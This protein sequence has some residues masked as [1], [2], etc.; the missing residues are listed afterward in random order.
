[1]DFVSN[2]KGREGLVPKSVLTRKRSLLA[3]I[4]V[5]AL[6]ASLLAVAAVPASAHSVAITTT[7][8]CPSTIPSAGFTDIGS[9]DATTQLAINCLVAFGISTGTT[10]TT[11]SPNDPVLRWQ[12]ALFL[13]RQA[14]DHGLTIPT[15]T[16]QGFTDIGG[17]PQATQDAINQVAAMEISRGTTT[18]TF[19]PNDVVSRWQ[20]ALFLYRLAGLAGV[21]VADDPTHNEFGD[22]AGFSAETRTAIN[23]L[24]DGHIALGTGGSNF[25]PNDAVFRW[26]MALFLTRTLA[27]DNIPPPAGLQVIVTP[28]DAV[29]LASGN[30][31]AF[32]AT[33]KN[34]DGTPYTGVVTLW[35]LDVDAS[36]NAITS[37]IDPAENVDWQAGT[38][39]D[40][41]VF[42][43]TG[44]PV[45]GVFAGT[46]GVVSGVIRHDGLAAEEVRVYAIRDANANAAADSGEPTDVGGLT[47]FSGV[48]VAEAADGFS[49]VVTVVSVNAAGDSFIA[50][51]GA[52][53]CGNGA[54][55]DCT[56]NHDSG[57]LFLIGGAADTQAN[58]EA[59]LNTGDDVTVTNYGAATADQSTFDITNDVDPPLTITDPVAAGVNVDANTYAVKGTAVPGYTVAVYYDLNNN[60]LKDA[61]EAKLGETTAAADGTWTVVVPLIQNTVNTLVATQRPTPATSDTGTGT[62]V[63]D[64]TETA[65]AAATLENPVGNTNGGLSTILDGGDTLTLDFNEPMNSDFAGDSLQVTDGTDTVTLTNGGN[66]SFAVGGDSSIIVV[67]VTGILPVTVNGNA[68]VQNLNGFFGTDGLAVNINTDPDRAFTLA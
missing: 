48:P 21:T 46:D 29:T 68:S 23:F 26:S 37:P 43:A 38:I 42:G 3:R 63:P 8:S 28:D 10:A 66:A 15:A 25:S 41:L 45:V 67:T 2:K 7:N 47:T 52:G 32:T 22:I 31:R 30:G 36:D 50:N 56:F 6:V 58:F 60:N 18:T 51:P 27:A 61:G 55:S 17:L 9:F 1:M 53:D 39:S 14:A 5:L 57:D 62:E 11:Y 40:G 35:I 16:N 20:M 24:A 49:G 64:I 65:T 34:A 33:F 4:A 12:M 19:S 13:V 59:A 54:G 44:T